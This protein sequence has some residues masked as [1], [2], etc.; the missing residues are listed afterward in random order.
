ML[1]IKKKVILIYLFDVFLQKFYSQNTNNSLPNVGIILI[2]STKLLITYF[3]M[4]CV[5]D[6]YFSINNKFLFSNDIY[7]CRDLIKIIR[8]DVF[9]C[10]FS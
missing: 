6:N 9:Y 8:C 4:K 3:K 1:V 7:R 2:S 10:V 5:V